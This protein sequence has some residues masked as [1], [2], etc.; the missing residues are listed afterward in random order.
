[1]QSS[2]ET[3]GT[4]GRKMT[5]TIPSERMEEKV[6]ERLKSVAQNARLPGFRPGKAPR[7][8]IDSKYGPAIVSEIAEQLINEGYR[9]AVTEN[10]IIPAGSPRIE[11]K[12]IERGSD[13]EFIAEFDV[14]PEIERTNLENETIINPV[15]TVSDEDVQNTID[16]LRQRQVQWQE[17][18]DASSDG[19]QINID[20]VGK[21]DGEL[22]EGGEATDF[23]MVLGS[24]SM[25][26]DFETV[27]VGAVKGD[28]KNAEVVFPDEYPG[29]VVA[30]K[31]ATFEITVKK[32]S[33]PLLPDVNEDFVNSLGVADGTIEALNAEVRKNLERELNDRIRMNV[34][35]QVMDK[36]SELNPIDVP[37]QMVEE[38]LNRMVEQTTA[39]YQQQGMKDVPIDKEQLR[40]QATRRV[41]LGLIMSEVIQGNDIK[42]DEDKLR[43]RVDELSSGYEMPEEFVQWHYADRSRLASMEALVLEDQVV[44][45]LVGSAV[46]ED[47]V[48]DFKEFTSTQA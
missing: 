32:V 43:E 8:L 7:K 36:M 3:I 34:K 46:S 12:K 38:E 22:F 48:V 26:P 25:L 44:Q 1:M 5:I 17:T 10:N 14:F 29:E 13:L 45:F 39:Q 41:A 24:G 19:D 20:F 42:L 28:I 2:L 6:A 9:E 15:C 40:P 27:L 33:H 18:D 16:S 37:G 11:A 21:I 31:T 47:K 35:T 30:G 23:D 4:I